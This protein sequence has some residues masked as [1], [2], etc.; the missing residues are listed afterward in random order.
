M[1]QVA[2]TRIQVIEYVSTVRIELV[3]FPIRLDRLRDAQLFAQFIPA[4]IGAT[5]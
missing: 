2:I 3:D 1:H 5:R 4:V